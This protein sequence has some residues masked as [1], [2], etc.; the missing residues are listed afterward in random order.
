MRKKNIKFRL[1]NAKDSKKIID[2]VEHMQEAGY[3][4]IAEFSSMKLKAHIVDI[5]GRTDN[6]YINAFVDAMPAGDALRL[7]TKILEVTPD[8]DLL[9]EFVMSDGYKFKAPLVMGID[10]FFP[11]L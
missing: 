9:Y 3:S 11:S 1:L 5:E 2:D 4:E 8:L 6:S 10:F 7:R